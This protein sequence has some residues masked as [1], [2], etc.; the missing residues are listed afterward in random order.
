MVGNDR[1]SRLTMDFEDLRN[2]IGAAYLELGGVITAGEVR[3]L[4]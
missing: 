1:T 4:A 3:L 2:R